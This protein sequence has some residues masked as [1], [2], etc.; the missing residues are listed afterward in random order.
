MLYELLTL[1]FPY[2][3]LGGKAGQPEFI[4]RAA[5]TL[6][7]PSQISSSCQRLPRSLRDRLDALVLCG[8][9]LKPE[10][11][12]PD[13]NAWLNHWRELTARFSITPKIPPVEKVL[14]R[15]IGWF[16]RPD[17]VRKRAGGS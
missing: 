11:R 8:L 4:T 1:Q 9:A 6:V 5:D 15:V 10:S 16:L 17:S 13:H 2:G 3:G 14:T 7:A 12:Y